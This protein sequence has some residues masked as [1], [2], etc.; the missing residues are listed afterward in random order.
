MSGKLTMAVVG[1]GEIGPQHLQAVLEQSTRARFV[2]AVDRLPVQAQKAA[3][4][5]GLQ[6][7]AWDEMLGRRDIEAV[8]IATPH[9]EHGHQAIAAMEAGKHVLLEKPFALSVKDVLKIMDLEKKYG[10]FCGAS[11]PMRYNAVMRKA[12]ELFISGAIGDF[13][14]VNWTMC[15]DRGENYFRYGVTVAGP[16]AHW[17]EYL[18]KSGG[19]NLI[20]NGVHYFDL[21]NWITG[22]FPQTV[23]GV[24]DAYVQN[25]DVEDLIYCVYKYS[26]GAAGCFNAGWSAKGVLPFLFRLLGTKGQIVMD[27]YWDNNVQLWSET[28]PAGIEPGKWT[29]I[30]FENPIQERALLTDAFAQKIQDGASD[31]PTSQDGFRALA[32]ILAAYQSMNSGRMEVVEYL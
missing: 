20:M 29:D 8:Y 32:P 5:F 23:Y 4:R 16:E 17:R 22:E 9:F 25:I 26:N 3:E 18:Q 19:G 11:F 21:V 30:P 31:A 15:Q 28:P 13:V 14:A 1:C 7:I 10:L 6:A 24:G 2:A 12:R 27:G